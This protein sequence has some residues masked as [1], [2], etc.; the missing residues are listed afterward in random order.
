MLLVTGL[1][2]Q[3]VVWP[4][5]F[6]DRLAEGRPPGGAVR[7]PRHRPTLPHRRSAPT[8]RQLAGAFAAPRRARTPYTLRDMADDAAG[9]LDHLGIERTHVIGVSMGGMIAQELAIGHPGRV[10]ILTSIMSNTGRRGKGAITP[11]LLPALAKARS[12]PSEP[13]GA[14]P[15]ST[16]S[17]APTGTSTAATTVATATGRS[18][19]SAARRASNTSPL[20]RAPARRTGGRCR[21]R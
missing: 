11:G 9:L 13:T 12:K 18:A 5:G 1:G 3:L 15:S 6:V 4:Q 2:A 20:T 21:R 8:I 7:Q 16:S 19:A 14:V 10:S 17:S